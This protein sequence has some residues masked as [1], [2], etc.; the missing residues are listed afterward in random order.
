MV[1]HNLGVA[2]GPI[3]FEDVIELDHGPA[4][5]SRV[6]A[7]L[8]AGLVTV[9]KPIAI[10]PS[11]YVLRRTKLAPLFLVQFP[12]PWSGRF[13]RQRPGAPLPH[14]VQ[15]LRCRGAGIHERP[16]RIGLNAARTHQF[17]R[18]MARKELNESYLAVEN[19]PTPSLLHHSRH[20]P[21]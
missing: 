16:T 11:P 8:C 9:A 2:L 1:Q 5:K 13:R 20:I 18:L 10:S 4:A 3:E 21:A 15:Y 17:D 12:I 6:Q 14:G 19:S 7:K